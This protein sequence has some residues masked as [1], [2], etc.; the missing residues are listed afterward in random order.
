MTPL[1]PNLGLGGTEESQMGRQGR[2]RS[3]NE[4]ALAVLA[5]VA[6]QRGVCH[7]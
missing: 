7:G 2:E 4:Q 6:M 3:Q 5:T 1:A